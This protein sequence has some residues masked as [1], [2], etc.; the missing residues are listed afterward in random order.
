MRRF[1]PARRLMLCDSHCH[2]SML[3]E[4]GISTE[5][6]FSIHLKNSFS[7]IM[8]IGIDCD[9]LPERIRFRDLAAKNSL[10]LKSSAGIFPAKDSILNK[11]DC[12]VR[13]RKSI[14]SFKEITGETV[15]A[16]GECGIDHHW[17][18]PELF[19]DERIL[20]ANQLE[21]AEELKIP[22]IVHSRDGF[23]DTLDVLASVKSSQKIRGVIH[24]FSYGIDEARSFLNEGFMISFSGAIT[25]GG[26]AKNALATELC[27][28]IPTDMLLLETDSPFLAPQ[29][30][31]GRVNSPALVEEI[32]NFVASARKISRDRLEEI[33][34]KNFEALFCK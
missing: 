13:L 28:F 30:F 21:L 24:C 31:R 10:C 1:D 29:K 27:G 2:L 26:K 20:F 15:A 6:L 8:D 9:D 19:R 7:Y 17:N 11:A 14:D 4:R 33:V 22:V 5:E 18:G 34:N 16:L 3:D 12:L 23:A 25:Y 32:Y